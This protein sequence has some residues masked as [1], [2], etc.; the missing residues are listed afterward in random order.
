MKKNWKNWIAGG[1][2]LTLL[3]GTLAVP[4][5]A[6][7]GQKAVILDYNNIKVTLDGQPLTLHDAHGNTVETFAIDGTTYLPVAALSQALGLKVSWDNNTKTVVLTSRDHHRL[8]YRRGQGQGDRPESR[9]QDRLFR[10]LCAGH[11]G[12]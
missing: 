12:L 5:L 11:S 4:A 6:S 8:L 7:V 10:D 1:V 2:V 3:A 9:G